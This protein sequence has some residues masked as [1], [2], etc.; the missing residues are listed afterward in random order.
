MCPRARRCG[1]TDI[2]VSALG[3]AV[4]IDVRSNLRSASHVG[5]IP[6]SI[7]DEG[8]DDSSACMYCK[9]VYSH[10]TSDIEGGRGEGR[11]TGERLYGF[12]RQCS[13]I[14]NY[15]AA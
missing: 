6:S 11:R 13:S 9:V 4:T 3:N 10:A 5:M 2:G 12:A 14:V 1:R 7:P 15:Y 8:N